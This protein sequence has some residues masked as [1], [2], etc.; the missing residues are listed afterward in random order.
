MQPSQNANYPQ[1]DRTSAVIKPTFKTTLKETLFAIATLALVALTINF[2]I[3]HDGIIFETH[4]LHIHLKW[5]QF[6]SQQ[7]SEGSLYPRWLGGLNFGYGSPTFTFYPPAVMYLGSALKALGLNAERAMAGLILLATFMAGL[8]FY[9]FGRSRWHC[10][11]ALCG[12]IAYMSAPYMIYNVYHRG[13]IAEVLATSLLPFGLLFTDQ[14]LRQGKRWLALTLCFTFLSLTHLPSLLLYAIAWAIYV[15]SNIAI[16]RL[17]LKRLFHLMTA[18]IIGFG[19]SSFYLIP[20]VLEKKLVNLDYMRRVSGGFAAN[21]LPLVGAPQEGLSGHLISMFRYGA[22]S[23]VVCVITAMALGICFSRSAKTTWIQRAL[24]WL[25]SLAIVG[26]LMT[27]PAYRLWA[28]SPTLQMVQ[29]PWRLMG[30][31]ALVY[32]GALGLAVESLWGFWTWKR[33]AYGWLAVGLLLCLLAW[34]MKYS[35]VLST[36]YPGFYAPGDIAAART[37]HSWQARAYDRVAL[38]LS[39]PFSNQLGDVAEYLPLLPN[40]E[41]VVARPLRDQPPVTVAKGQ[42]VVTIDQ[43]KGDYRQLSVAVRQ[44]S[45]LHVRTYNY[46]AWHAYVN[47]QS[48]PIQTTSSGLIGLTL[49]PGDYRIELRYEATAA[50]K[51][52]RLFSGLS[53]LCLGALWVANR[54]SRVQS[55]AKTIRC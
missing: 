54:R 4:D 44:P 34:N 11:P 25:V 26:F 8:G 18:P 48:A 35:Y 53:L 50:M 14:L 5:L 12:A 24:P 13:A 6:F 46:P 55:S 51:L 42:A 20:A 17:P 38:T 19:L 21:F 39:A 16:Q 9:L 47:G 32:A 41:V 40:S 10:V 37:E 27:F 3:L 31:F 2:K 1:R 49:A 36:R 43:W 29:F 22:A 45:E 33:P 28:A 52:G 30:L 15:I 23:T 7:L